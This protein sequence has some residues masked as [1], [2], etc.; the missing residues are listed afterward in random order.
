M[1]IFLET[2]HNLV[3]HV[4]SK[5]IKSK[6]LQ[7]IA[8]LL[9]ILFWFFTKF[10]IVY[11]AF[12]KIHFRKKREISRKSLFNKKQIFVKFYIFSWKFSFNGNLNW[13]IQWSTSI[14]YLSPQCINVF[15]LKKNIFSV[16]MKMV[17]NL[18]RTKF[19]TI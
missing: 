8:K 14:W 3:S 15:R 9:H 11:V 10:C 4:F 16:N 13:Y 5:Q 7:F 6:I 12:R 19:F 1:C 2:S 18:Y 17:N